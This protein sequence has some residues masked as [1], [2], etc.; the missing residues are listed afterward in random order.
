MQRLPNNVRM[1][2][3]SSTDSIPLSNLVELADRVMVVAGPTSASLSY[4]STAPAPAPPLHEQVQA[5][6]AVSALKPLSVDFEL[7][8]DELTKLQATVSM[9]TKANHPTCS[10]SRHCSPAPSSF[11]YCQYCRY[12]QKFGDDAHKCVSPCSYPNKLARC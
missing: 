8:L 12:H 3:A 7:I 1:V 5:T 11:L 9:L 10:S 2:L 6:V 4:P